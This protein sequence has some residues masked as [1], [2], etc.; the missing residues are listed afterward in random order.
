MSEGIA[1]DKCDGKNGHNEY[2]SNILNVIYSYDRVRLISRSTEKDVRQSIPDSVLIKHCI[3]DD[4]DS[5]SVVSVHIGENGR[6]WGYITKIEASACNDTFIE[7]I[8]IY[9]PATLSHLQIAQDIIFN[10][11]TEAEEYGNWYEQNIYRLYNRYRFNKG[12]TL[13]LGKK[14]GDNRKNYFRCY[15]RESK[16]TGAP[17]FHTEFVLDGAGPIHSALGI[18]GLSGLKTSMED[19]FYLENSYLRYKGSYFAKGVKYGSQYI[20][21]EDYEKIRKSLERSVEENT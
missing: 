1:I 20:Q 9:K 3:I 5:R 7:I 6:N 16:L 14:D 2:N 11:M 12:T 21:K 13:Y 8:K 10:T 18:K 15:P 19:Y 4:E 17:C